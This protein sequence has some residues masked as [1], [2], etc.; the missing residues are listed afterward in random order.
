MTVPPVRLAD[1]ADRIRALLQS[2]I[3]SRSRQPDWDNL[4]KSLAELFCAEMAQIVAMHPN[5]VIALHGCTERM[6]PQ[7]PPAGRKVKSFPLVSAGVSYGAFDL[8]SQ[9]GFEDH[10]E[11]DSL[12]SFCAAV[13]GSILE[14]ES[15]S[16]E[17]E[18]FLQGAAHDVRGAV[19]RA[20][21]FAQLAM[22]ALDVAEAHG[23]AAQAC[24]ELRSLD[25]L[26]K[27]LTAYSLAGANTEPMRP[28]LVASAVED[29][30]WS[31]Q[32]TLDEHPGARIEFDQDGK[33]AVCARPR[34]LTQI[35][36]RIVGNSLKFGPPDVQIQIMGASAGDFVLITISDNGPGF[37]AQY[38]S[39]IFEPFSRLHG[40]QYP[41]HGL[42]LAIVRKI[43]HGTGGRV[44]ADAGQGMRICVLL[45]RWED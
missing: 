20:S 18:R 34:D 13:M 11:T 22:R 42:G 2:I 19:R 30:R 8:F 9:S 26:L 43:V 23:C 14:S 38:A 28:V 44:W 40:K 32:R 16:Y 21:N 12:G 17:F 37:E 25:P 15:R 33:L 39:T 7:S 45:P 1:T 10:D 27:D 3:V 31:M 35:L 41:G 4:L 6:N 5:R 24:D 36:E 29:M